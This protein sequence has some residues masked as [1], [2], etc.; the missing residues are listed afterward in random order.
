[1]RSSIRYLVGLLVV[2]FVLAGLPANSA[3]AQE[4]GAKGAPVVK[5]LLDNDK[6]RVTETTYKPGDA[7]ASRERFPRLNYTPKS[8]MSERGYPDG[9]KVKAEVRAGE[10]KWLGERETYSVTNI[11]KTTIVYTSIQYK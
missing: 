1:M 5:V 7:S 9:K 6:V 3:L 4:K 2:A 10:W 11:G 8:G